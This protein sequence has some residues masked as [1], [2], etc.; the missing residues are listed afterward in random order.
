MI[1]GNTARIYCNA[2]NMA[3]GNA[4]QAKHVLMD[5]K[6]VLASGRH[7]FRKRQKAEKYEQRWIWKRLVVAFK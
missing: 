4:T 2:I 7:E 3:D 6:Y 5:L 1:A